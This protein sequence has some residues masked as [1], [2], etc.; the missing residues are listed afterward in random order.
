MKTCT[1]VLLSSLLLTGSAAAASGGGEPMQPVFCLAD[2]RAPLLIDNVFSPMQP[3]THTIFH[4]LEDGL[5]KVNDVVITDDAK[6]D[7]HAP[8]VGLAARAVTDKVWADPQCNGKRG[9]LLEDTTD[10]YGQDNKGNVW[11]F[12]EDTIEYLFDD[13][14]HPLGSSREGSWEAGRGG[15]RAGI[16]MYKDPIVGTYY[17][18]E[19]DPGVAEDAARVDKVG[20]RVG[21]RLGHFH[22]CVKTRETTA[23]S[24]EDVEYKFYCAN[25]GLVRVDSPTVDGGAELI[26]LGLR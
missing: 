14:G 7:F 18:Q 22:E 11:Y 17:R 20:L 15:A 12:G 8:Y 24:P 16:V 25:I 26:Q 23:L 10:W 1:H 21:T 9:A 4:E 19:Y 6:R 5:C 2:F 3:G 13:A